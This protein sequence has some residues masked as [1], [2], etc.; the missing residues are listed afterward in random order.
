[1]PTQEQ[2]N[3]AQMELDIANDNYAKLADKYNRYQR[4]F[5]SYA[6]ATPEQQER[7][8]TAMQAALKDYQQLR[9][10]MYATED[11]IAQA[12]NVMN[13]INAQLLQQPI[14]TVAP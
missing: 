5:Q 8:K 6:N 3:A 13:N 9:L 12:Q 4:I 10:D 7:A 14:Q 2:I 11:R 1:M